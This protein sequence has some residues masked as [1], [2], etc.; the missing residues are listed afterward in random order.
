M[1][2]TSFAAALG[3]AVILAGSPALA[4]DPSA[5]AGPIRLDGVR[6]AQAIDEEQFAPG[7]VDVAFTN[8]NAVTAT[9]IV[10][11][12]FGY[13]GALI[14]QYQDVGSFSSSATIRH[15]FPDTHFDDDQKLEVD[16][17][18]F[19]DGTSWKTKLRIA[20]PDNIFPPE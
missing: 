8:T 10:F 13:N 4:H 14:A 11:D 12:L 2:L 5:Q 17:V 6:I 19:A 16:H 1:N 7:S 9:R 3:A 15:R 18:I 20:A